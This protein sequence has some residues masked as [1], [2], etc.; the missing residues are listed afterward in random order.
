MTQAADG[1]AVRFETAHDQHHILCEDLFKIYK[2][3]DLE[4]VALRALDLRVESGELMAIVGASG[5]G[6]STL[7][8]ILAG[9]DTPSAGRAYVG[10]RNLLTM[11]GDELVEYRRRQVGFIWQQTG[12]N[13]V[14]YLTARENVEIP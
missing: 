4:V 5:S 6:K 10:G 11:P 8:N 13:L 2:I 1:A 3:A 9:L 14:P 12:R 7:L